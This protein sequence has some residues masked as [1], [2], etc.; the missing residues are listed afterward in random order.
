MIVSVYLGRSTHL[1]FRD[2]LTHISGSPAKDKMKG[3]A[4]GNLH[5]NNEE[6]ELLPDPHHKG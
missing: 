2:K 5:I 1:Q 6:L 3:G 4:P